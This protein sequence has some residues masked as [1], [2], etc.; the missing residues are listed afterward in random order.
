MDKTVTRSGDEADPAP[1]QGLSLRALLEHAGMGVVIH[2]WDSSVVY[3][4][5]TALRLLRMSQRQM[6]GR[7]AL[8]PQWQFV[9]ERGVRLGVDDYPVCRVLRSGRA[10]TSC[11]IGVRDS[12]RDGTSWF[13]VVAYPEPGETEGE[14]FVVV[15]FTETGEQGQRLDYE[16]ILRNTQD[17]VIV[18]EAADL[19]A[20]LGPRMVYV[21]DAFVRLTGYSVEEA[22]GQTPRLLQGRD[23][24]AEARR[25]IR[26]ALRQGQPVTETLLNYA[27][28]GRP[29]WLEMNIF[30]LLDR[31]GQLTHFAAIERDVTERIHREQQLR[32]RNEDLRQLRDR[33]EAE[34]D[35]RTSQLRAVNRRL[36]DLAFVDMLTQLPNRRSLIQLG[37]RLFAHA[38]RHGRRLLT[39]LVDI[40]HFKRINDRLGHEAGDL[41]LQRVA[42]AIRRFFRVG[43]AY[44]RLG[45]EEFGFVLELDANAD[46]VAIG[47][48]LRLSIAG[49][50]GEHAGEGGLDEQL[51]LTVSIG[52][53]LSMPGRS[54]LRA[55]LRKADA[56]LYQAKDAG[57]NRVRLFDPDGPLPSSWASLPEG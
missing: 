37:E 30:P 51:A 39:G 38:S 41:A 56:A 15:A 2:R 31:H 46:P 1:L 24:S 14:G 32:Q 5:P 57:R 44:G 13:S 12:S 6:I 28:D 55:E 26:D 3:A 47:E 22:L 7:D 18:T 53:S 23:T 35:R 25:R 45:G 16:A 19:D 29:Y 48:R 8:D 21:N 54:E 34:V 33:L 52:L 42:L 50:S 49:A 27:K 9:D 10:I 40:D 36:E 4:N 20:P 17:V 11:A 43:D